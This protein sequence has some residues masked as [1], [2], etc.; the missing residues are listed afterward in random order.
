MSKESQATM[1]QDKIL[2]VVPLI[3]AG[4]SVNTRTIMEVC[5]VSRPVANR[6]MHSL[7]RTL[8]V[9]LVREQK[10]HDLMSPRTMGASTEFYLRLRES[11]MGAWR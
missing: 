9:T 1:L 6:Y 8:P 3:Y 2:R 5:G 10:R 7:A 4:R 11:A